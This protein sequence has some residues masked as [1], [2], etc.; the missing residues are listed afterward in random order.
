MK[1]V[2]YRKSNKFIIDKT[3]LKKISGIDNACTAL[4]AELYK[5]FKG[6]SKNPKYSNLTPKE[7]MEKLNE[8]AFNWLKER[9]YING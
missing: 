1:Q 4:Y 2:I 3:K 5:E 6:A 7:K 9:G 8:F